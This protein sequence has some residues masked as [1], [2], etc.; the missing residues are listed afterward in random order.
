[1]KPLLSKMIS[2]F[3]AAY[4]PGRNIQ[5]NVIIGHE[6]VHT[7]KRKRK[8]D[9]WGVMGLKLDTVTKEAPS[10]SHLLF[11]DDCLI[12]DKTSHSE[13]TNLLSLIKDFSI[14]SGQNASSILGIR[15][16]LS[17]CDRIICQHS[18]NG[19]FTVKSAYKIISGQNVYMNN[20]QRSNPIYRSLWKL[21]ILPKV[22]IFAWKCHENI[23]PAKTVLARFSNGH[24]TSCNMCNSGISES[25]KHIILH[26]EFSKS[27]W[28]LA[29]YADIIEQDSTS[30]INLHDWVI[31]WLSDDGLIKKA[32]S[33]FSIAWSIWKDRC[34][35]V[36]QGKNLNHQST[37]RLA[38]MLIS[39]TDSYLNNC[40]SHDSVKPA[41]VDDKTIDHVHFGCKLKAE[42]VR[43][44]EEVESL[45]L[46]E[47][48]KWAKTKGLV[49]VC[50]VSDA[51]IVIDS[52]NSSNNQLH[53]YNRTVLDDG[54]TISSCF[55]LARFEFLHRS[56]IILADK[57]AKCS[58]RSIT[59]G[60]WMGYIPAFLKSSM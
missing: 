44:A 16:P 53:W 56:H 40:I 60:E 25:P 18:N 50:F 6:L 15:I 26:C 17:G 51:K 13:A 34:S 2:P 22:Q 54:K 31:K 4:V 46:F 23:L 57:A 27:V 24:D 29:P 21:P 30:N 43:N 14:A 36:F 9:K 37:A 49:K 28:S 3:Q 19:L 35:S 59:S 5:D 10:I 8:K 45:A 33:V 32:R 52:F 11:P 58:R 12:F 38:L 42:N 41:S 55:S 47:E 7:M 48:V 39:D 20:P 1:M